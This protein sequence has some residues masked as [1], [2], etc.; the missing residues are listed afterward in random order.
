MLLARRLTFQPS[1]IRACLSQPLALQPPGAEKEADVLDLV[2]LTP[3]ILGGT[4]RN[5]GDP[6]VSR[7]GGH[8]CPG[9]AW[10]QRV[11]ERLA[12]A[13]SCAEFC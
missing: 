3:G 8:R 9:A 12:M 4:G 1:A 5:D 11:T 10:L 2:F 13:H 6:R 7:S